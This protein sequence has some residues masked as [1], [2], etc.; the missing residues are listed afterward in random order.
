MSDSH[1]AYYIPEPSRWP[2]VGTLALFTIFVG[3]GMMLN[4]YV[5][6]GQYVLG[7]GFL[8][9]IYLFYGWFKDVIDESLAGNYN[10]QGDISF[11]GGMAWFIFS[12]VMF[13]AAFSIRIKHNSFA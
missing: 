2:I 13:F 8:A 1:G 10:E 6:S 3:G 12:E 11:R 9:L 4:G 7:L 5:G